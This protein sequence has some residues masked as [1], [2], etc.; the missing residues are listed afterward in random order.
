MLWIQLLLVVSFVLL[1]SYTV[2]WTMP[3]S[4]STSSHIGASVC[5]IAELREAITQEVDE[6][7]EAVST[8]KALVKPL[9][10]FI[11]LVTSKFA[12]ISLA[13]AALAAALVEVSKD[14]SPGG[15]HGV[16]VLAIVLGGLG[17]TLALL[18][19]QLFLTEISNCG[20]EVFG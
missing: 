2:A 16:I 14:V 17:G 1:P 10:T 4:L 7:E 12:A 20:R 3:R 18:H 15:H 19:Y 5:S 9:S 11:G 6:L 13:V 8:R